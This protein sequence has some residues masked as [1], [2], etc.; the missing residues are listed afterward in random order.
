MNDDGR[1]Y[2]GRWRPLLVRLCPP[3][4]WCPTPGKSP[5]VEGKGW[6]GRAR[7]RL[8]S[9]S[10]SEADQW[11]GSVREHVRRGGN[12]GI[13][14]VPHLAVLDVDTDVDGGKDFA[15]KALA[16]D[17]A[18]SLLDGHPVQETGSMDGNGRRIGVHIWGTL[19]EPRCYGTHFANVPVTIR[20]DGNLVV[21]A[22]SRHRS[23]LNYE[24]QLE[25]PDD[26]ALVPTFDATMFSHS[27]KRGE[28]RRRLDETHDEWRVREAAAWRADL[29]DPSV[30]FKPGQRHPAL[31]WLSWV[32]TVDG[33]SEGEVYEAL[34]E[35][36]RTRCTREGRFAAPAGSPQA[37][38]LDREIRALV[39][40]APKRLARWQGAA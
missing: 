33:A 37:R 19:E 32:L 14:L 30:M 15:S 4:C 27:S 11:A 29:L 36:V 1:L 2:R 5:H 21:V 7:A 26:P 10:D 40:S 25:L 23:G 24:W 39:R 13:A 28:I 17:P 38:A 9:Y 31:L 35:L 22:P 6:T 34:H 18:L 8:E 20:G 16:R 12:V 3:R